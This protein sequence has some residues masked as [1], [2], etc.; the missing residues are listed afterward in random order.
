MRATTVLRRLLGVRKMFVE[1][2]RFTDAG[3]LVAVR[4]RW[5]G[6]RCG[7]CGRK[8]TIYDHRAARL[9]RHQPLGSLRVWLEYAPRRVDC[10]SCG[11]RTEAVPWA[12][13]GSRFTDDFE[14]YV[15][16][17]AQ[18]TDKTSVTRIVG[19]AW[20]SV[21]R[22]VTRVVERHRSRP[23]CLDGLRWIG[24]D[25][26]SYRR[27]HRYMTVVVDHERRRVVWAAEGR[28]AE[29]LR[30]FFRE[31]GPERRK[32][33]EFATVDMLAGYT[34]ALREE[35]PDVEIVYDR[36]H[37]ERLAH[38]AVD[39]VRR[40]QV[41]A[42][43]GTTMG[44]WIKRSRYA[45]LKSPKNL[46]TRDEERLAAVREANE[47]LFRAYLLKET[48]AVA[49]EEPTPELAETALREWLAWASRSQLTP[50]KRVA[51]TVRKHLA[52]ILRYVSTRLTNGLVEGI[53]NRLRT[54]ARRSYGYHAA[55][56]L[57][58]ML[59]LCCGDVP[60]KPPLPT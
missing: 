11:V 34:Q 36:F 23:E 8:G 9:W 35:V 32:A 15:A 53:N 24:I 49:L 47:P 20:R 45:L 10:S 60:I 12:A 56:P 48:L 55:R 42:L 26:F 41:R 7:R 13:P 19:V 3:L 27:H 28:G 17:L 29:P 6:P 18:V 1:D 33:L 21:D 14:Q 25:D 52:G 2:A 38:E 59:F 37:V 54:I 39:E 30:R 46:T 57:I 40:E 51:R 58:A 50:F 5:R 31:L 16:Y 22:I 44:R 43:G 4:P